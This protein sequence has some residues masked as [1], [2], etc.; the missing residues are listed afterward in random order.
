MTF[1]VGPA[2]K[3]AIVHICENSFLAMVL[4]SRGLR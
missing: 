1:D 4:G 3:E 2:E